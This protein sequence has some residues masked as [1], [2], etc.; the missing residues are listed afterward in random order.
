MAAMSFSAS[1]AELLRL[2]GR[3]PPDASDVGAMLAEIGRSP[4]LRFALGVETDAP[5]PHDPD[6]LAGA[7]R[8]FA[9]AWPM[10]E[11]YRTCVIEVQPPGTAPVRFA[12]DRAV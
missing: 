11:A 12:L 6:G 5:V 9:A 4:W 8:E 2:A 1:L 7:A 3:T 10:W